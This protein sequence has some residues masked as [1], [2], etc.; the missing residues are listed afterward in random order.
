MRARGAACTDIAVLVVAADDGVMPQT[1]EALAH[2]RVAGCPI[3]VALT[4]CDKR[5]ADPARVRRQLLEEGL[6]LEAAGGTVQVIE[7]AAVTGAGLPELSEALLLEA[8][9]LDLASEPGADAEGVVLEARLD[10]GQGPLA[11]AL[12]RRGTARAF[13]G[14]YGDA[15]SDFE[16]ARALEP[17]NR[18]AAAE[19]ERM[20]RLAGG[21]A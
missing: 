12:L 15:L 19:I 6:A 7:V 5:G 18:D 4:K 16:A 10:R 9:A 8:D 17:N 21:S 2:A 1:R 20:R 3:V 11:T 13:L 14:Q